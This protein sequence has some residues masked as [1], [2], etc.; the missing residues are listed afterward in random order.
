MPELNDFLK[1]F[2]SSPIA[3]VIL[4]RGLTILDSNDEFSRIIGFPRERILGLKI[5][6]FRE[7]NM[8]SYLGDSGE[9]IADAIRFKRVTKGSSTIRTPS[10]TFVIMRTNIPLFDDAGEIEYVH[11]NYMDVT[12]ITKSRE[13][14]AREIDG[15]IQIYEQIA[16]GDLT[17][18]YQL[19]EPDDDTREVYEQLVR[20]RDAV[21]SIIGALQVNI[22]DV[23]QRMQLM[24]ESTEIA[25]NNVH[26]ASTGV[27]QVAQ[28]MTKV[29]ANAEQAA[30]GISQIT[31]AMQDLSASVEE[32]AS[33]MDMVLNQSREA[34]ELSK[35]GAALAVRT[36][37]SMGEISDSAAKVYEIVGDVERRM[38]EIT[39]IVELIRDLA[40]QTNLLALNAAIEAARA[41]DAGRGFAVVAA[42]VKS[43]AQES[44]NSAERI[45]EMIGNLKNSTQ[46][47]SHA[48]EEAKKTVENG[49]KM[50]KETLQAFNQIA[51]S[52]DKVA[53]GAADIAAATEEQAAT[54]EEVTA[55]I[56]EVAVLIQGTS[57]EVTIAASASEESS[58][59][60]DEIARMMDQVRQL[61]DEAVKANRRFRVE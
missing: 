51:T 28:N 6:D 23:N 52:V 36:E 56:S 61:A 13:F 19:S 35:S 42:E 11:V 22:K 3:Q 29:S 27:Q 18:R 34:N 37:T 8:I 41:G 20:L 10:G 40:N 7:K 43:L 15:L 59:A 5:T 47:A 16:A 17:P 53:Q 2:Q 32:I 1:M 24:T 26:D 38:G 44:R 21:R 4:D 33:S 12:A 50:V 25:R 58:A 54:T 46:H 39:K 9:S 60:L 45:E 30:R 14:M 55:S 31:Q 49:A 48:M 57:D